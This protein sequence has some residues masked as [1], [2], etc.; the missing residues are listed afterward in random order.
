MPVC[1]KRYYKCYDSVLI[2]AKH[3]QAAQLQFM[4]NELSLQ[5]SKI[6]WYRSLNIFRMNNIL[7]QGH[8]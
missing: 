2:K 5:L 3:N 8:P 1:Q 4:D 7:S 6:T